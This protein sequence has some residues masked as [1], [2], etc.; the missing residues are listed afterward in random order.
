MAKAGIARAEEK[1]VKNEVKRRVARHIRE[2]KARA[3]R[4]RMRL[5]RAE[6]AKTRDVHAEKKLQG[7]YGSASHYSHDHAHHP[8]PNAGKYRHEH[9]KTKGEKSV[10]ADDH[11]RIYHYFPSTMK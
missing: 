9:H 5:E 11:D 8:P 7:E 3:A 4:D 1:R 10:H 2:A 6:A